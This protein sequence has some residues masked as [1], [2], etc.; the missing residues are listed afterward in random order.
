MLNQVK[1]TGSN[2]HQ[3]EKHWRLLEN[4]CGS[5]YY[6]ALSL[7]GK[8]AETT[9]FLNP[10]IRPLLLDQ[11]ML[12]KLLQQLGN[13]DP[14]IYKVAAEVLKLLNPI[15]LK[16]LSQVFADI[17]NEKITQRL[18]GVVKNNDSD[19]MSGCK[20]VIAG[21][22]HNNC[23]LN[24]TKGVTS[25][26]EVLI[27]T[28]DEEP[29]VFTGYDVRTWERIELELIV[30]KSINS[31]EYNEILKKFTTGHPNAEPTKLVTKL[32]RDGLDAKR[33]PRD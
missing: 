19:S 5:I 21:G 6:S 7:V 23:V 26:I 20:L 18:A 2:S 29:A 3:I 24:V 30:L 32:L 22:E 1:M 9:R 8:S 10:K 15:L 13:D 28:L 11:V 27:D 33:W 12:D 25:Q 16:R 14:K 4:N 31:K 17:I